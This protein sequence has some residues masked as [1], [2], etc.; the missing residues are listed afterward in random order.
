MM[1]DPFPHADNH[2]DT[3]SFIV[4]DFRAQRK[5]FIWKTAFLFRQTQ[6]YMNGAYKNLRVSPFL[7]LK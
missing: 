4:P 1:H 5:S 3:G 6:K 2:A 7:K